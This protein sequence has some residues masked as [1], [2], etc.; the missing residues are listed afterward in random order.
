MILLGMILATLIHQ[1]SAIAPASFPNLFN[2]AKTKTHTGSDKLRQRTSSDTT[3]IK[4]HWKYEFPSPLENGSAQI[5]KSI[6][7]PNKSL[8]TQTLLRLDRPQSSKITPSSFDWWYYDAVSSSDATESLTVTLFTS[9]A[10]AFPWLDSSES[11]VLIAYIWI[12]FANGSS[13]EGYVPATLATVSGGGLIGVASMGEWEGTGFSWVYIGDDFSDYEVI[14]E[15]E[16]MDIYRTLKLTSNLAPHLPRGISSDTTTLEIENDFGWANLIPDANATVDMNVKGTSLQFQGRAYHD[17]L[18]LPSLPTIIIDSWY[19]GHG[20]IGGYSLVW[21]SGISSSNATLGSTYVSKDGTVL[22]STCDTTKTIVRPTG[23]AT[24]AHYPPVAGDTPDGFT[25]EI[26]LAEDEWLRV[27]V[28]I[29]NEVVG[30]GEYH[31]RWTGNL[32]GSVE[33]KDGVRALEGGGVAFFEQ[34]A[35]VE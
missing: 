17:K 4:N 23:N 31:I 11:S 24:A 16:E 1:T 34:F 19:W 28:S 25:V 20:E 15:S 27:N 35:L 22:V 14:I 13:F 10:N 29:A 9:C 21:F 7:T 8:S 3:G 12:S 26:E 6:Q 2:P 32:V 5:H 33:D 18:S 30:D